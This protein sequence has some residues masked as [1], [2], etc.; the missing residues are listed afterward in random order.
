MSQTTEDL[1]KLSKEV[2]Q[3]A[4]EIA[5]MKV[6][7]SKMENGPKKRHLRQKIRRKQYQAW[8]YVDKIGNIGKEERRDD[9]V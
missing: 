8:F 6:I 5:K 1:D 2:R 4:D 7:F 9:D 3:L